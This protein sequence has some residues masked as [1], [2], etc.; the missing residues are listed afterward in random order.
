MKTKKTLNRTVFLIGFMGAGKSACGRK[1]SSMTGVE[2]ID[3]DQYIEEREKMSIAEIFRIHGE[4]YFRDLETALLE[5]ISRSGRTLIVSAGGGMA[6]RE[7][8]RELMR[9]SGVVV[10][11][12]ADVDTLTERLQN[13]EK[14][15]LLAGTDKRERILKLMQERLDIYRNACHLQI[16]TDQRSVREVAS[17][18]CRLTAAMHIQEA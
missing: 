5:E 7:K 16:S 1:L 11:L 3:T 17:E 10:F 6:L 14:R 8:N 2:L 15:P 4:A 9:R 13:D 18:I 12:E